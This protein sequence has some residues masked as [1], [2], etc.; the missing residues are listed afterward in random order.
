MPRILSATNRSQVH[1]LPNKESVLRSPQSPNQFAR[2]SLA[3]SLVPFGKM[4]GL[5]LK[6]YSR[7]VNNHLAWRQCIEQHVAQGGASP[8]V[9]V[10]LLS[11]TYGTIFSP[12]GRV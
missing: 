6:M 2:T 12:V 9:I 7:I 1:E 5:S 4:L 3:K 10:R 11:G 8:A